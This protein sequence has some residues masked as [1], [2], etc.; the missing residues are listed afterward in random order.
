MALS[1]DRQA[2]LERIALLEREGRFDEDV[3]Q[4]PPTRPL[5]PGEADYLNEKP[6]AKIKTEF[7]NQCARLYFDHCI[8]KG[9]L[10]IKEIRGLEHYRQAADKGLIITCNH[11][12]PYDQYAVFKAIQKDLGRKRLYKIIRE[13]NFT[14]FGGLFGFFFRHC[15]TLP[16]ASDLGVWREFFRGVSALLKRGEKI[17]IY[18]E[19]GMWWNYR[20]P[21]PLKSGAFQ[22]AAKNGVPVLPVFITMEDT[23]RLDPGGAPIQAYTLHF[24]PAIY[25]DAALN[26]RENA[27]R[28]GEANY[29]AWKETYERV[30]GMPLTYTTEREI[31][32]FIS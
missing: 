12:N 14:S 5:K 1:A 10:V 2:V 21:R 6:F 27:R 19:Q 24:L 25:P 11:F 9:Q 20:K 3:E 15:N 32:C 29:Q 30:Y 16:L 17:L 7:A 22:L 28:M 8:R 4:D 23:D 18:P 26:H 31:S 13:G